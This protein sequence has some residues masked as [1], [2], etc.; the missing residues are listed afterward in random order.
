MEEVVE[1]FLHVMKMFFSVVNSLLSRLQAMV[2]TVVVVTVVVTV[3]MSV[4]VVRLE[5][6]IFYLL[7]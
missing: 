2:V 4:V 1:L 3:V 7:L 6:T 5:F